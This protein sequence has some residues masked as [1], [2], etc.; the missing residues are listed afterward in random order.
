MGKKLDDGWQ[1]CARAKGG[2]VEEETLSAPCVP[3]YLLLI[4]LSLLAGQH[5]LAFLPSGW[6]AMNLRT[7]RRFEATRAVVL[8]NSKCCTHKRFF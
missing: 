4:T 5:K 3:V 6:P 7:S 2:K 1:G 8:W